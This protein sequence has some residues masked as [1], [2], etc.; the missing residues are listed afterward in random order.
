LNEPQVEWQRNVDRVNRDHD[1]YVDIAAEL[2][3]GYS[4]FIRYLRKK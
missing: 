3:V 1:I 2:L 4:A